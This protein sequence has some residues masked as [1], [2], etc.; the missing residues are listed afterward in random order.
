M[1]GRSGPNVPQQPPRPAGR[2]AAP[3]PTQM[4]IDL[5]SENPPAPGSKPKAPDD[6][7]KKD[8]GVFRRFF[9]SNG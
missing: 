1:R 9:G 5:D 3:A 2:P 6:P 4:S 7:K 8:S